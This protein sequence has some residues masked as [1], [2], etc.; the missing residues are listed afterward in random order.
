M[1]SARQRQIRTARMGR[2]TPSAI[3]VRRGVVPDVGGLGGFAALLVV[4]FGMPGPSTVVCGPAVRV[5]TS[6]PGVHVDKPR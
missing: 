1:P 5:G 3:R 4:V 2:L 6:V